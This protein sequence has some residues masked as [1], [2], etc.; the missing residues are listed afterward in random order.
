M[1]V[2]RYDLRMLCMNNERIFYDVCIYDVSLYVLCICMHV[3]T[4]TYVCMYVCMYIGIYVG[5][6]VRLYVCM[7]VRTYICM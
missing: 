5:I 7:D 3:C 6:H 4:C 1:Y 2:C